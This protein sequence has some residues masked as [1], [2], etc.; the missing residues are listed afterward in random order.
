MIDVDDVGRFAVSGWWTRCWKN[1]LATA[2]A[3]SVAITSMLW[4]PGAVKVWDVSGAT[5]LE[6]VRRHRTSTRR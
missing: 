6:V 4:K 2:P 1:A 5:R 3:A